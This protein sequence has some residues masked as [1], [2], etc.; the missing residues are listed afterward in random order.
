MQS[1]A[2]NTNTNSGTSRFRL[3]FTA[4]HDSDAHSTAKPKHIMPMNTKVPA[5]TAGA[6]AASSS[7]RFSC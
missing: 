6:G 2:V 4:N 5:N 1:I 3:S 7:V